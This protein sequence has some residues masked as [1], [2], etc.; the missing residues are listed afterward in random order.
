MGVA[1]TAAS[2]RI[3]CP[4][5]A[6]LEPLN[7]LGRAPASQQKIGKLANR[8]ADQKRLSIDELAARSAM[9]TDLPSRV[10]LMSRDL[11]DLLRAISIP[12]VKEGTDNPFD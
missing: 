4:P 8:I 3:A 9:L 6:A 10:S 11:R 7:G 5:S 12:P 2:Y 1:Y